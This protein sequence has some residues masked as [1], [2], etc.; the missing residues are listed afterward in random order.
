MLQTFQANFDSV[1]P[2]TI[3]LDRPIVATKLYILYYNDDVIYPMVPCIRVDFLGCLIA[4]NGYVCGPTGAEAGGFCF[5]TVSSQDDEA[6]PSIFH[7]ISYPAI[8]N[9]PSVNR[10]FNSVLPLVKQPGYEYYRI[11]LTHHNVRDT[12]TSHFQWVDGTPL[13]YHL[14]DQSNIANDDDER[15][16]AIYVPD[17][18]H[19]EALTCKSST[20][21]V[22]TICQFGK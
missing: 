8:I 19:W 14:F 6:C 3:Y 5:T 15:C 10:A 4:D 18:E 20:Q 12:T 22:G 13:T 21:A 9:S 16:P 17:N 7:S 2:V 11:G 1:T